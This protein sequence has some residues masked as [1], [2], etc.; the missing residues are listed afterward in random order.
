MDIRKGDVV[1][2][3]SIDRLARNV[4][5]LLNIIKTITEERKAEIYFIKENLRFTNDLDNPFNKLMLQMIGSIAEFE[6]NIIRSRQKEGIAITK[7][8]GIYSKA[9]SKKLNFQK[10]EELK[11]DINNKQIKVIDICKKYDI[12]KPT[13]YRYIK[14]YSL[15]E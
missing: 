3:H 7:A 10:I 8:K 14:N 15:N 4:A 1:E 13:L 11:Q 6:R 5:D 12:T 9:R 2:V